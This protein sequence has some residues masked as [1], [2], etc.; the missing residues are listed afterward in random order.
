MVG[1]ASGEG[2]GVRPRPR[3]ESRQRQRQPRPS[4]REAEASEG[5]VHLEMRWPGGERG[6][7]VW[8][9]PLGGLSAGEMAGQMPGGETRGPEGVGLLRGFSCGAF[10]PAESRSAEPQASDAC[11]ASWTWGA[12]AQ[13]WASVRRGD[14]RLRGD[15]APARGPDSPSQAPHPS[16]AQH[17]CLSLTHQP[18]LLTSGHFHTCPNW[19]W[20]ATALGTVTRMTNPE[21]GPP[22]T[23]SGPGRR[24]LRSRRPRPLLPSPAH[25]TSFVVRVSCTC[26][27]S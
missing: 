6:L 17:L 5:E 13:G 25:S 23:W 24:S 18:A 7:Q 27:H 15:G 26:Q 19:P 2:A 12:G 20:Q 3:E 9:E 10:Q 22:A 4:R 14:T 21:A 1:S 11:T 16:P 8:A